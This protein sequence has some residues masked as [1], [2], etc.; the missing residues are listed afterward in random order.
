MAKIAALLSLGLCCMSSFAPAS[1][2][3]LTETYNASNWDQGMWVETVSLLNTHNSYI[4]VDK[5]PT[6]EQQ[7]ANM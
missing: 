2:W 1:A 6:S 5:I 4:Q 3:R 7:T